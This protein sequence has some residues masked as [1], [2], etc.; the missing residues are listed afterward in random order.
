MQGTKQLTYITLIVILLTMFTAQAHSEDKE[1][2]SITDNPGFNYFKSTLLHVIEQRRPELSGQHHFY[3]AHYREGSEYTYMFW[4]EARLIWVLHLGTPE[5]Y[6]WMSM[7]LPSSGELLHID[8]DV[9][10]TQEE[11]GASTYMV[12]QQWINDKI[13]KCVVDGD[14]I[15]VTYP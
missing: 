14:L 7:L 11:V 12:S 4:Q 13:F 6:G 8:K 1:L 5:E 10:A 2:T 15:T 3:V 9:V